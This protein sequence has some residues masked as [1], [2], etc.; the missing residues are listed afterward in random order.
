VIRCICQG[1][2]RALSFLLIVIKMSVWK[3]MV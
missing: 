3:F 2:G 1:S